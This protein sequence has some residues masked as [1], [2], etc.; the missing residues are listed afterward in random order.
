[1]KIYIVSFNGT[2][3]HGGTAIVKAEKIEDVRPI[4]LAYPRPPG[5]FLKDTDIIHIEELVDQVLHWDE[6]ECC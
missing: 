5:P 3:Y 1:M 2:G 6:G 4:M